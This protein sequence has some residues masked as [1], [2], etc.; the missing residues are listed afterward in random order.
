MR[1]LVGHAY[2]VFFSSSPPSPPYSAPGVYLYVPG[3]VLL[4]SLLLLS[5]TCSGV[6]TW[7][8]GQRGEG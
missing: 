6:R 8:G 3:F 7:V 4:S 5:L 1:K 2:F